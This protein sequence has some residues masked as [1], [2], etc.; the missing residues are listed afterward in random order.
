METPRQTVA[1]SLRAVALLMPDFAVRRF[2]FLCSGRFPRSSR[3]WSRGILCLLYGSFA[4]VI[5]P[6]LPRRITPLRSLLLTLLLLGIAGGSNAFAQEQSPAIRILM[7][8]PGPGYREMAAQPV[9]GSASAPQPVLSYQPG[10]IRSAKLVP[11]AGDGTSQI[12]LTFQPQAIVQVKEYIEFNKAKP[13]CVE[14]GD[15]ILPLDT[16]KTLP[17]TGSV[18]LEARPTA[19]ARTIL[20][21]L[22]PTK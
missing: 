11:A 1:W 22:S 5:L 21:T 2:R 7:D 13:I 20:G 9:P 4:A 17:W 6:A 14:I 12:Q 16:A 10:D 18:W 15:Y 3:L 8:A 19:K